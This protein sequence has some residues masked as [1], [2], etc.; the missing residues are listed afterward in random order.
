MS[1]PI[2]LS[3]RGFML[4]S[5]FKRT[6]RLR[7]WL[8]SVFRF[9]VSAAVKTATY[10]TT[11]LVNLI[12]TFCGMYSEM[13]MFPYQE[14][15][16]RRVIRSVLEN[17]GAEIT[18]L[19]ARQSG[20]TETISVT[21]GGMMIILPVLANLDQF[22]DDKRIAPFK[23]GFWVGIFAP[24]QRQAQITYNRMRSRLQCNSAL[25][26]LQEFG[27]A[28]S[29]SN[30]QTCSLTNGS[31]CTAISASDGSNIEGE[32]FKLI[33]CEEC[34][35]ISNFK[36]RKSIHPMGAAY[37]ATICKIGTATTFKG[38]FYE[39]ILRNKKERSAGL[40]RNHFEYDWT[41]CAKYNPKYA[42][43]IEGEKRKLG[44][45]SDEFQMS[46]AL[47]W[48]ISRGMF[49]DPVIFENECSEPLLRR[50]SFDRDAVHVMGIDVASVNDSTVITVVEVDWDSP[51]ILESR[52]DD[53]TGE[54]IV[55]TAYNTYIKDWI[56]LSGDYEEQ[57]LRVMEV[58]EFY[59]LARIVIDITREASFGA[60]IKANTKVEVVE[61]VWTTPSKS[62]VYKHLSREIT[63]AR[64]KYPAHVSVKETV[65]YEKF[66][67]QLTDLQKGYSGSYLVVRHPS[68][69][70][71]HD[72][73]PDSWA[74]A[75]WGASFRGSVN[76]VQTSDSRTFY[77]KD[78]NAQQFRRSVNR[79][80]GRR[81]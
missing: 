3:K 12:Y 7:E 32:S 80:T 67:E 62:D 52:I 22:K 35:D 28:F 13:N 41:V 30:G 5:F 74:L 29:T 6:G 50:V 70:D 46:Y 27:I 58:I 54:E 48:I 71:A 38:D 25:E 44:M 75:V 53:E 2:F 63:A 78:N 1:H 17:D 56:E 65:E 47:K 59:N 37:N 81:R 20:K 18:A 34:Q 64:A 42:K 15:Y 39:A 45:N 16:S 69:R 57:Y 24:S 21:V 14:Q 77:Q 60:R 23:D 68:E 33:I 76:T 31:F 73:Y 51:T 72:D 19:F 49:I 26:I 9:R 66:M 43:Y 79:Y 8:R 36:I 55:Y 40:A 10:K 4:Y 11:D 61:F